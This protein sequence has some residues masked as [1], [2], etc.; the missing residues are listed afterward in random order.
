MIVVNKY[1]DE[2]E[3][4]FRNLKD[5]YKNILDI[6][7][8]KTE[9]IEI[10]NFK[11]K[12]QESEYDTEF[13][14]IIKDSIIDQYPVRR[15]AGT[16][17]GGDIS[18]MIKLKSTKEIF[19]FLRNQKFFFRTK[20]GGFLFDNLV[21]RGDIAFYNNERICLLYTTTEEAI[22]GTYDSDI[23]NIIKGK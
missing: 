4:E 3:N 19:S 6:L 17:D 8:D 1:D 23:E 16:Q 10:A 15:W 21:S 2:L 11:Y 14:N 20:K 9:Y 12:G 22:V 5:N 7:E 13:Y 18:E